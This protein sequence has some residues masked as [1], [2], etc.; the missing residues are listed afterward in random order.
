MG[1]TVRIQK[2]SRC[3]H[4]V[5]HGTFVGFVR[6]M[7]VLLVYHHHVLETKLPPANLADERFLLGV[8]RPVIHQKS[9]PRKCFTTDLAFE[10]LLVQVGPH[11]VVEA[12]LELELFTADVANVRLPLVDRLHVLVEASLGRVRP[13]AFL[14]LLLKVGAVS[15]HVEVAVRLRFVQLV[16]D[17]AFVAV[18][19]VT[20]FA[21]LLQGWYSRKYL[22]A[23]HA[24]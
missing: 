24:F 21:V 8:N 6:P 13:A 9:V 20:D 14:A 16:A 7:D 22:V 15:L 23:E 10:I 19:V 17:L 11:V 5:T 3:E 12:V 18:A 1:L 4:P 2:M